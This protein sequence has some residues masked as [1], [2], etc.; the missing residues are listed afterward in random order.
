MHLS[1]WHNPYMYHQKGP[2]SYTMYPCWSKCFTSNK[3]PKDNTCRVY[4]CQ[5][6]YVM[7]DPHSSLLGYEGWIPICQSH[8]N[9]TNPFRQTYHN[10]QL[11]DPLP[12]TFSS[13]SHRSAIPTLI[14]LWGGHGDRRCNG[15]GHALKCANARGMSYKRANLTHIS[16]PFNCPVAPD[17]PLPAGC[18]RHPCLSGWGQRRCDL[19]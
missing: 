15:V 3:L 1:F 13:T 10:L 16:T 9:H 11:P 4:C 19:I 6:S 5:S 2:G 17:E 14:H 7:L 18:Q 12:F 8:Y